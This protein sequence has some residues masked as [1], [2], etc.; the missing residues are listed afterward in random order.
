MV[1]SILF[2]LLVFWVYF[3]Y[4]DLGVLLLE[5]SPFYTLLL[6][7]MLLFGLYWVRWWAVQKKKLPLEEIKDQ[8]IE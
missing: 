4:R 3:F 2:F 5:G 7:L 6:P 1:T 8:V